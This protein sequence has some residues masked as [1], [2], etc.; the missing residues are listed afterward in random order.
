MVSLLVSVSGGSAYVCVTAAGYYN[1]QGSTVALTTAPSKWASKSALGIAVSAYS[2]A[3]GLAA[4]AYSGVS[5][6]SDLFYK[7]FIAFA[8]LII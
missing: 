5:G 8:I 6:N 1:S 3:V 2:P 7:Y 4:L